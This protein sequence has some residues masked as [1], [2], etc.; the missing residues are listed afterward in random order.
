MIIWIALVFK[1]NKYE[2]ERS[3][4]LVRRRSVQVCQFF[5]KIYQNYRRFPKTFEKDPIYPC[6]D[7]AP[8][9]FSIIQKTKLISGNSPRSE[10]VR[11]YGRYPTK[12][13]VEFNVDLS[14]LL[15]FFCYRFVSIS[16]YTTPQAEIVMYM[17]LEYAQEP[18]IFM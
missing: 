8:T 7:H 18:L 13:N 15:F 11:I 9:N 3:L 10:L 2:N 14:L 17:F 4:K 12:A 1:P 5:P 6:L 16:W